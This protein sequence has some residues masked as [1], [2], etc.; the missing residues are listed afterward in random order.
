MCHMNIYEFLPQ[1]LFVDWI[2]GSDLVASRATFEK[3]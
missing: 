2:M 1:A 3:C